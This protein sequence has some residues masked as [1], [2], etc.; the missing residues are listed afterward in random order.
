VKTV[1]LCGGQGW[2]IRD[3]SEVLPKPM[4]PIGNR[5]IVWHIMKTFSAHGIEDFVLCLGY[6]GWLF[7]E[8]FLNCR[9]VMADFTARPSQT[10]AGA[11]DKTC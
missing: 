9:R 1:I 2:R 7:K 10:V 11:P 6:K 3:A 8:F 5:P 4:L